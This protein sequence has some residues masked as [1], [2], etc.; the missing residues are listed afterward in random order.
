MKNFLKKVKLNYALI[1]FMAYVGKMLC[2]SPSFPEAIIVGF[3][4]ALYGYKLRIQLIEPKPVNESVRKEIQE[5]KNALS[6][7]NLAKISETKKYF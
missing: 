7:V 5:I 1:A 3:L 4:A 6:K 2:I